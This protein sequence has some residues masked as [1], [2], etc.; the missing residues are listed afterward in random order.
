[1]QWTHFYY[2]LPGSEHPW[3]KFLE[4]VFLVKGLYIKN[5]I[6]ILKFFSKKV[7]SIC[8]YFCI[9]LYL[10]HQLHVK[11]YSL[12]PCEYWALLTLFIFFNLLDVWKLVHYCFT[13][14]PFTHGEGWTYF[15]ICAGPWIHLFI[16]PTVIFK[17]LFINCL[18]SLQLTFLK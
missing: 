7:A 2:C 3:C 15:Q 10:N 6:Y 9:N 16:E 5:L 8:I 14:H 13:F 12:H 11:D 4:A 17:T 18:L 1:M